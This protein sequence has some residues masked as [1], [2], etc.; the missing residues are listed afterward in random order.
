MYLP[1]L[2]GSVKKTLTNVHRQVKLDDM[3]DPQSPFESLL[4]LTTR[5]LSELVRGVSDEFMQR[6]LVP[7]ASTRMPDYAPTYHAGSGPRQLHR[8]TLYGILEEAPGPR[9]QSL[10]EATWSAY[11]A[12]YA[13][14]GLERRPDLATCRAALQR[15]MPELVPTG[16]TA[17]GPPCSAW[18]RRLLSR[19]LHGSRLT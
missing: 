7:P 9:W 12:W 4:T 8:M 17:T 15:H 18:P 1:L 19:F 2:G 10:F 16:T 5:Q 11:R 14:E 6:A 3:T 13:S